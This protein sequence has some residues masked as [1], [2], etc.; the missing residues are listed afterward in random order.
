MTLDKTGKNKNDFDEL[1]IFNDSVNGLNI[2]KNV[3]RMFTGCL[4]SYHHRVQFLPLFK[5]FTRPYDTKNRRQ[6]EN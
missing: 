1:R 2:C 6:F 5:I 3:Y 4:Y